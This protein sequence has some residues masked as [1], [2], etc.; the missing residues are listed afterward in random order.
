[1]RLYLNKNEALIVQEA[2]REYGK[3]GIEQFTR[4]PGCQWEVQ[5][6]ISTLLDRI[7]LCEKLQ[8]NEQRSK[9]NEALS[10]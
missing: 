4:H 7:H 1:M 10:D 8:T 2:L 9:K 5:T 6:I 3:D